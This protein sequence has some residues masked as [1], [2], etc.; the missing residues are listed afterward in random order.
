MKQNQ[1]IVQISEQWKRWPT[2]GPE[3]L[4]NKIC[5]FFFYL[6]L[7]F[8]V[9]LL[10]IFFAQPLSFPNPT[11]IISMS[12]FHH[13]RAV[14]IFPGYSQA[15][16]ML[17]LLTINLTLPWINPFPDLWL[18]ILPEYVRILITHSS[19]P[20]FPTSYLTNAIPISQ[21]GAL[22]WLSEGCQA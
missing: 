15:C 18:V 7:L 19:A 5:F 21:K 10:F 12:L 6:I 17:Q 20:A 16:H 22:T 2:R 1:Y 13:F 8:F 11:V 9:Y 4:R 14:N 3:W